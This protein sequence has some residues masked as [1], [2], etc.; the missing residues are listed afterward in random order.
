MFLILRAFK[1][2]TSVYLNEFNAKLHGVILTLTK[3]WL[4]ENFNAFKLNCNKITDAYGS[5]RESKTTHIFIKSRFIRTEC[6]PTRGPEEVDSFWN[7]DN[8]IYFFIQ[9]G[10]RFKGHLQ[11][12]G[13]VFFQRIS[14][15]SLMLHTLPQY[16]CWG[17]ISFL[18]FVIISFF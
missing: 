10:K 1:Y 9:L 16:K 18:C 12:G 7:D 14:L 6:K 17:N 5:D 3:V 11:M 4:L 13:W 2:F 15:F 8:G